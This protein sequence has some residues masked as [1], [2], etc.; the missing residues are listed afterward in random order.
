MLRA[1]PRLLDTR[2]TH[3]TQSGFPSGIAEGPHHRV[4]GLGSLIAVRLSPTLLVFH[5]RPGRVQPAHDHEGAG[6][7]HRAP[8]ARS[9]LAGLMVV[10]FKFGFF[11]NSAYFCGLVC[12]I[13]VSAGTTLAVARVRGWISG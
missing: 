1:C 12:V 6:A 13:A 2:L 8:L 10:D 7:R 3:V 4:A 5:P 11:S 9:F